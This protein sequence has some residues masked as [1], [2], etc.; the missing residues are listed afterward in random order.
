MRPSRRSAALVERQSG[1]SCN[2]KQSSE[3]SYGAQE[4]ELRAVEGECVDAAAEE[5]HAGGEERR[6][7]GVIARDE[8]GDRVDKLSP[9]RIRHGDSFQNS[10]DTVQR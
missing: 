8:Q 4:P 10:P 9:V 1:P 7:Q 5:G 3:G 2:E 6:S